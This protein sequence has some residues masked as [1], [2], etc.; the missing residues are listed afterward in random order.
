MIERIYIKNFQSHEKTT[1][2]LDPHVNVISGRSQAGK[3]A[4]L[5]ALYWLIQN[6][7]SGLRFKSKFAQDD[8]PVKVMVKLKG[9]PNIWHIKGN[10]HEYV[11]GKEVFGKVGKAVP[12]LV[13]EALNFSELNI[14]QQL[15]IPFLITGSPGN[16][17]KTINRI[18]RLENVDIWTSEL[19]TTI[20]SLNKDGTRLTNELLV[21]DSQIYKFRKLEEIDT[22]IKKAS[23][24]HIG[25]VN[26]KERYNTIITGISGHADIERKLTRFKNLD[27]LELTIKKIE[28]VEAKMAS[29]RELNERIKTLVRIIDRLSSLN[30]RSSLYEKVAKHFKRGEE[31]LAQLNLISQ[32]ESISNNL[33]KVEEELTETK[34]SYVKFMLELNTCPT[35]GSEID[36][37]VI[38][39]IV[40]TL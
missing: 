27:K 36:D 35:C 19:T 5:R 8:E 18:T 14:Q 34:E 24:V 28:E 11:I 21:L 37:D 16:I 33:K 12:D 10:D 38:K 23:K 3:T 13:A 39:Q 17:A 29:K 7:P 6:R 25:C 40:E 30:E 26:A 32:G 2:N 9:Q 15:D 22:L 1:L 4:I 31:L 20:N